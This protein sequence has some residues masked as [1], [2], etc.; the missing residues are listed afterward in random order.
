MDKKIIWEIINL[1]IIIGY[2]MISICAGITVSILILHVF[3]NVSPIDSSFIP[4]LFI[5]SIG[6]S[7]FSAHRIWKFFNRF[8]INTK[9][10]LIWLNNPP[11]RE[12]VIDIHTIKPLNPEDDWLKKQ[13]NKKRWKL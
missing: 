3:T 8:Y 11:M 1:L 10:N 2:T 6:I 9:R 12:E 5:G 7:F 4:L 13:K